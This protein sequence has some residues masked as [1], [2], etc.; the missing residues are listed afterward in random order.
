MTTFKWSKYL[1]MPANNAIHVVLHQEAAPRDIVQ[2]GIVGC[3]ARYIVAM[4]LSSDMLLSCYM[5][6]TLHLQPLQ[7]DY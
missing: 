6:A 4:L 1:L 3:I 2:V 7:Y 5:H